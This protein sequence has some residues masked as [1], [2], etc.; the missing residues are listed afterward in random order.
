MEQSLTN[1]KTGTS[2]C[3]LPSRTSQERHILHGPSDS[4][5]WAQ[6]QATHSSDQFSDIPRNSVSS[7]SISHNCPLGSLVKTSHPHASF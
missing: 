7:L 5:Q 4:P 1:G 6:T 2:E 3:I